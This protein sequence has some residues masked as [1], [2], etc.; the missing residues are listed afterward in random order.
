M[1]KYETKYKY[2][3]NESN[4]LWKRH[5]SSMDRV[6]KFVLQMTSK[7]ENQLNVT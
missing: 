1:L 3:V 2:P 7:H 4:E 6:L 5:H